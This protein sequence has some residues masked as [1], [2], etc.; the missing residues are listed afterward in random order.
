[1][2]LAVTHAPDLQYQRLIETIRS[3]DVPYLHEVG[4]RDRF[5]PE[6]NNIVKTTLGMWYQAFDRS[7]NR[8]QL[9]YLDLYLIHQPFG[10]VFG[11]WRG[12][13]ELYRTGRVRAI[14]VS[15]FPLDRLMDLIAQDKKVKRGKLTFILVRG[16]GNAFV[17]P[18]V[19]PAEVRAL[20][21]DLLIN[22][23]E[24]FRDPPVFDA[25]QEKVFP[26]IIRD[27]ERGEAIRPRR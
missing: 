22:V 26:A 20:A 14:G 6:G 9:D 21:E 25:V 11:A 10:D 18:D 24:F 1:M 8:L 15:N 3:F 16:I 23:T 19:D 12:M 27:R 5:L 13:E 17:A 4:L 2:I 7:L